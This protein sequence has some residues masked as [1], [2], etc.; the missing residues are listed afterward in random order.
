MLDTTMSMSTLRPTPKIRQC[1]KYVLTDFYR[2]IMNA[3][4]DFTENFHDNKAAVIVT[5]E[6]AIESL[7]EIF[8]V[9][10]FYNGTDVPDGVFDKFDAIRAF[11]DSTETQGYA[12]LVFSTPHR[13]GKI[14][15][16]R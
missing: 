10:F 3:T 11:Y 13:M 8:V 9:F 12:D 1:W 2:A 7:V 14:T 4:Q 5:A 6:I 16:F 15:D